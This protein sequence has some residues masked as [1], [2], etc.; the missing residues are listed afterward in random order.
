MQHFIRKQVLDLQIPAVMDGRRVQQEVGLLLNGALKDALGQGLD[1]ASANGATLCLDQVTLD[2]GVIS[3]NAYLD[4]ILV[5]FK[6]RLPD[7]LRQQLSEKVSVRQDK[8]GGPRVRTRGALMKY[9][10]VTG[11]L[12]WWASSQGTSALAAGLTDWLLSPGWDLPWLREQLA[13][14]GPVT[15]RVLAHLSEQQLAE[16]LVP[17]LLGGPVPGLPELILGYRAT[18]VTEVLRQK[19]VQAAELQ[20]LFWRVLLRQL[21]LPARTGNLQDLVSRVFSFLATSSGISLPS[22]LAAVTERA[23][24]LCFSLPS[25]HSDQAKRERQ[26]D[27]SHDPSD[28]SVSSDTLPSP[29][30]LNKTAASESAD[31]ALLE[32]QWA[33][34]SPKYEQTNRQPRPPGQGVKE[35]QTNGEK[36][37]RLDQTAEETKPR[38]AA[39]Q[40][41]PN[42]ETRTPGSEPTQQDEQ[43]R[44]FL[45]EPLFHAQDDEQT[46]REPRPPGQVK[47]K[48]TNGEKRPRPVQTVEASKAHLAALRGQPNDETPIS[49]SEETPG[50][51][52][53]HQDEQVQRFMAEPLFHAQDDEQTN[54]EGQGVK[55]KQRNK[56]KRPWL[57]QTAE[58][59]KAR[60]CM[61]EPLFHAQDEGQYYL[62]NAGLVLLHPF[63]SGL[64]TD[65]ELTR[66]SSFINATCRA[67]AVHLLHQLVT[68]E[69]WAEEWLCPLSKVLIGLHP[70]EPLDSAA[71]LDQKTDLACEALLRT[72]ITHWKVLKDTSVQSLRTTF[73][74][75]EGCLYEHEG[76]WLLRVEQK[77]FDL[78]LDHIPWGFSMIRFSWMDRLLYVEWA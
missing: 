29:P 57:D 23:A 10:L 68:G 45:A 47:E 2:L 26:V 76:H 35:K 72:A 3:P 40:G 5:R 24:S 36:R 30:G 33:G 14:D 74:Q 50:S 46:N 19:Q 53:T 48:Q 13:Q 38:L 6:K 66:D 54:R 65:M 27:H 20:R 56:E 62:E 4:E 52:P 49:V 34:Q 37:P 75:R 16:R 59:N 15:V 39:P 7:L 17:L 71:C 22:L 11:N 55:E 9:V 67:R 43:A 44:R 51:E 1:A 64:F 77:P 70:K 32:K 73:L 60:E 25:P 28:S 41:Q 42:D 21:A 12:P 63:L 61:A 58:E 69:T 78:L 31:L 8:P 18:F